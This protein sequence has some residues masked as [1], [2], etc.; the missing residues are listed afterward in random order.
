MPKAKPLMTPEQQKSFKAAVAAKAIEALPYG[1]YCKI[2]PEEADKLL[3]EAE[4]KMKV[5][6]KPSQAPTQSMEKA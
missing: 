2:T 4:Q 3:K 6:D 1:D 5:M